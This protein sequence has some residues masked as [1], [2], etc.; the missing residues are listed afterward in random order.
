MTKE[1][2][3]QDWTSGQLNA[4]VK[5]LGEDNARAL[6]AGQLTVERVETMIQLKDTGKQDKIT[7]LFD[8]NGFRIKPKGLKAAV[9]TP[10]TS[11]RL[12]QPISPPVVRL[13]RMQ[14]L[15]VEPFIS[16]EE[17]FDRSTAIL[18]RVE[19]DET[20]AK[21]LKGVALPFAIPQI[22]MNDYG[23]V[24]DEKFLPAVEASY[25]EQFPNQPFNNYRKGEL[26]NQVTIVEG[27]RHEQLVEAMHK[28]VVV[29][30]YFPNCL[31]G[32]SIHAD[33]EQMSSLPEH[34]LLA[35][36][37]DVAACMIAYPDVLARDGN[38]PLLDLAALQWQSEQASLCFNAYDDDADF[39]RRTNLGEA[40][41]RYAGGLVVLG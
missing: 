19:T 23:T 38:T 34:F 1:W 27:S 15:G 11:Y 8:K 18:K 31:Q 30:V 6:L 7:T 37:F 16:S 5:A 41:G 22:Q 35:G 25:R 13:A 10:N 17:F 14:H 29:G 24:L 36:G 9:T 2:I 28:G 39:D 33:R 26:A 20:T 40:S 32:F 3:T 21:L 4:I 12:V